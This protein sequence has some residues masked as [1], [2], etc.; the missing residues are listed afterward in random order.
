[1][2][3]GGSI[4]CNPNS[5]RLPLGS[6]GGVVSISIIPVQL[7]ELSAN[8][9]PFIDDLALLFRQMRHICRTRLLLL[10]A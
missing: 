10:R 7:R 4:R 5:Q 9:Q 8:Q 3:R 1:M 6:Y 2:K